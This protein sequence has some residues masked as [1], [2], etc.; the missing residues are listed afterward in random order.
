LET[1]LKVAVIAAVAAVAGTVI[2]ATATIIASRANRTSEAVRAETAS[3]ARTIYRNGNFEESS[4]GGGRMV[5][6]LNGSVNGAPNS[7]PIH[8]GKLSEFCGDVDGCNITLAASRFREIA[9]NI[10]QTDWI[11]AAPIVGPTCRFYYGY[12]K[13]TQWAL[14]QSCIA[15][16]QLMN[17]DS[18]TNA[19]VPGNVYQAYEYGSAAGIDDDGASY[20]VMSFKGACYLSE[21]APNIS[22]AGGHF[23]PDDPNDKTTGSGLFLIASSPSWDYAPAYPVAWAADDPE[24]ECIL[25]IDD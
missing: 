7:A 10:R 25:T 21:A 4:Y 5:V 17:R 12:A 18:V 16:Y 11:V 23:M 3:L 6:I 20:I 1:S 14:S 13:S 19:W 22:A 2:S 24:R 9:S 15:T 8:A